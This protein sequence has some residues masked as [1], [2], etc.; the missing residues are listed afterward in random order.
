MP[1]DEVKKNTPENNPSFV[2]FLLNLIFFC[3]FLVVLLITAHDRSWMYNAFTYLSYYI[4]LALSA[5][6]ALSLVNLYRYKKYNALIF[7]QQHWRG[8]LASFLLTSVVFVS[9]PKYFRV[10]SDET[11]LLSVA[12]SM[13]FYKHVENIT[14]GRWYYEMFWPTPTTGLEKRPF[15]FPFVVSLAHT[16]LGYHVEN[17]FILNYFHFIYPF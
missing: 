10:L 16:L 14:E 6:W 4:I 9:V 13:T 2:L 3:I 15:L 8:I 5:T 1:S 11:N 12:K 17:V 7:I